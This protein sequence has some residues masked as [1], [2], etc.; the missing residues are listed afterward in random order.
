MS[1]FRSRPEPVL[2]VL[3]ADNYIL[4][5]PQQLAPQEQLDRDPSARI[6]CMGLF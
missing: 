4:V 1:E 2:V 5:G 3:S 6:R